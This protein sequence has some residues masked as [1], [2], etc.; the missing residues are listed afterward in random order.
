MNV[1]LKLK[2]ELI[3]EI[4]ELGKLQVG[5][6]EYKIAA[7]GVSKIADRVIEIKKLEMENENKIRAQDMEY[8]LK[9]KEIEEA[10]KDRKAKNRIALITFGAG[11]GFQFLLSKWT[12]LFEEKGTISSSM[13]RNLINKAITIFKR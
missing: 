11:L 12:F 2:E 6:D 7:D 1:E 9:S 10:C 4:G 13:G 5:S 8:D 3:D